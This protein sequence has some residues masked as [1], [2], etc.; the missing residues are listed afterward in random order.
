MATTPYSSSEKTFACLSVHQEGQWFGDNGFVLP[1]L[2]TLDLKGQQDFS[3]SHCSGLEC[4]GETF[5]V[6]LVCKDLV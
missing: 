2:V 1:P 4:K 3:A 6:L 5:A